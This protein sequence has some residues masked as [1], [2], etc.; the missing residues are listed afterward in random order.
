M[1]CIAVV[2]IHREIL[3]L[4]R[5]ETA[6]GVGVSHMLGF[7]TLI[8]PRLRIADIQTKP[9]QPLQLRRHRIAAVVQ[10]AVCRE[11]VYSYEKQYVL[12]GVVRQ[13]CVK[14]GKAKVLPRLRRFVA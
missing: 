5:G 8:P 7:R 9:A 6:C 1:K 10:H 12:P 11:H 13:R 3:K 2:R 4:F 14:V